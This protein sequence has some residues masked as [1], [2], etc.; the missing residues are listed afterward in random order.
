MSPAHA[1][2]GKSTGQMSW[3][4]APWP[5]LI[6]VVVIQSSVLW[7]LITFRRPS[8]WRLLCWIILGVTLA[9]ESALWLDTLREPVVKGLVMKEGAVL[10]QEPHGRSAE[11]VELSLG[12]ECQV[13]AASPRWLLVRTEQAEGWLQEGYLRLFK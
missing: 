1:V 9:A 6:L 10:R 13:L 3:P 4:L 11:K 7:F 5:T 8:P 12:E 2:P